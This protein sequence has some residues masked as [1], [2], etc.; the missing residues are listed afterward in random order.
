MWSYY[1][2][3]IRTATLEGLPIT[4]RQL[5]ARR[6]Q[7]AQTWAGIATSTGGVRGQGS[8]SEQASATANWL[9]RELK[10]YLDEVRA[11]VGRR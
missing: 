9:N 5:D 7:D 2:G 1:Q 8:E 4:L 6:G 3:M 11:F 10:R